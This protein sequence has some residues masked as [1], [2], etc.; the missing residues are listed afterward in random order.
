MSFGVNVPLANR[1]LIRKD[2]GFV[3]QNSVYINVQHLLL[4]EPP[5]NTDVRTAGS[6]ACSIHSSGVTAKSAL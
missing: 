3:R 2:F 1:D 5:S 6:G 4:D